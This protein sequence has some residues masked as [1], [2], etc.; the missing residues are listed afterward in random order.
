MKRLGIKDQVAVVENKDPVK[1]K[2]P[3]TARHIHPGSII[4]TYQNQNLDNNYGTNTIL[5][6]N[7]N[8]QMPTINY[9]KDEHYMQINEVNQRKSRRLSQTKIFNLGIYRPSTAK[10]KTE[11][12]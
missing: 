5:N 1:K 11:F 12:N 6:E 3:K 8:T 10:L 9:N 2:R 4:K 7:T